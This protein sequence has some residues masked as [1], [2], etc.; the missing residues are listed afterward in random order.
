MKINNLKIIP[1]SGKLDNQFV[2]I[3]I[4]NNQIEFHYPE[5][6]SLSTDDDELR[7]DIISILRTISL[8]KSKTSDLSSY[9]HS[10]YN[11]YVFPLGSYLWIINDYLTYG[12]YI[13]IEKEYVSDGNGR[14]NWKRTFKSNPIISG[15]N[16]VYTN[17]VYEKKSQIDNILSTIY[18]CCVKKAVDNIG[19]LY[20][21][22]YDSN[23]IDYD[24]LFSKNTKYYLNTINTELTHTNEDSKKLRLNNMKNIITG[25]DENVISTQE[26]IYGVDSYEYVFERMIDSMFSNIRNIKDFYPSGTWD[27][28]LEHGLKDSSNLR[29]DTV[30]IKDNIVYILDAKYYRYGT[31]FSISDIP[32][33]TSIQKQLTYGEYI[34]KIKENEYDDVY[35]AFIMPYSMTNNLH[36]DIFNKEFEFIGN[37]TAKWAD[38]EEYK[39]RKIAA[40]LIDTKYLINNWNK[41]DIN[42]LNMLSDLITKKLEGNYS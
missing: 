32:D 42:N 12:H 39:H 26:I 11:D 41:K 18:N 16:I 37:A 38:S 9:N 31:T 22:K 1:A 19:W 25:L 28:R 4:S 15:K 17:I 5:S 33:T 29:P 40:I 8:A 35:N 34:K 3:R 20:G 7:K 13:N 6:Y 30:F 14:I 21:I 23:G 27:L 2:G 24:T 36:S 10:F